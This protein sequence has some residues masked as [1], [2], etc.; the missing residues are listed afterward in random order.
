VDR[1]SASR[2]LPVLAE[3][4]RARI[5]EIVNERGSVRVSELA[6]LIGVAQP[7]V[8]KDVAD[9]DRHRLLRRTHGGALALPA[10]YEPPIADR[11]ERNVEAKEAI[12]QACVAEIGDGDAIY[13]DSGTT[14]QAIARAMGAPMHDVA[15]PRRPR[16]VNVLTNA[17]GVAEIL[18][19]C[20]EIRTTV[21]GGHFRVAGGCFVGPLAL[22]AIG[23]FTVN[24]AFIAVSGLFEESLSVADVAEAQLKRAVMDRARR[25]AV[26]MD[27]TK[28]G[29]V[30]FVQLCGLERIDLLVTDAVDAGLA[31]QCRRAGV[32]RIVAAI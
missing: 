3:P 12:A 5:L 19:N 23:Q 7:T 14:A 4:R 18:S 31:T 25:V 28:I 24:I 16:N 32:D 2:Q 20:P 8:R 1:S 6:E 13:L 10:A 30:D 15:G 17:I 29:T 22:A 26:P 27:A 11:A 9:L 21:L